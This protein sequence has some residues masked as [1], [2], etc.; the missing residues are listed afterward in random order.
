MVTVK[1]VIIAG[2]RDIKITD[3]KKERYFDKLKKICATYQTKIEIV[4][5]GAKGIDA[6][7]KEF[8]K[9]YNL[10]LREF[11]A[12]WNQYGKSAGPIR[13]KQMA[14]Y[15][16]VLIAFRYKSNPSKG[17]ENMIKTAMNLGLDIHI[18]SLPM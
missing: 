13:N 11:P 8:A 4:E 9:Y 7:A 17:T 10:S 3:Y 12:D 5:G 16:D 18:I 6:L 1:K 15:A 2:P 14:E